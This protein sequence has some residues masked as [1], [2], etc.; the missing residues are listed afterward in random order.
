MKF[1]CRKQINVPVILILTH[2]LISGTWAW[3][4]NGAMQ[5]KGNKNEKFVSHK[6]NHHIHILAYLSDFEK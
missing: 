4:E 1:S 3:N 5:R 6:R 2:I